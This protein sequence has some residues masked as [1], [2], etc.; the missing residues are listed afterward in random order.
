MKDIV[1]GRITFAS[2]VAK[3]WEKPLSPPRPV[4]KPGGGKKKGR[5]PKEE[6]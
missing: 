4:P 1:V 3:P 5:P 2:T 6:S